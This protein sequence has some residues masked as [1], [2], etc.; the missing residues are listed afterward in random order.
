[1]SLKHSDILPLASG[2]IQ[3]IE[4]RWNNGVISLYR[5]DGVLALARM[6]GREI[7]T[8]HNLLDKSLIDNDPNIRIAALEALPLVAEQ[9]SGALFEVLEVLLEDPDVKVRQAASKCLA[10]TAAT[11]PSATYKMLERELRHEISFRKEHAWRGLKE[12]APIWPEVTAEHLDIIFQ[13]PD[14]DLRRRGAKILR[15]ILDKGGAAVWDLIS[16]TLQ[17]EDVEVRRA[18]ANTLRPLAEKRPKIA[19]IIAENAL[20][21]PDEVVR[22]RVIKC[23]NLLDIS[24]TK[25]RSLVLSG[26]RHRDKDVR[27]ACVKMIPRLFSEKDARDLAQELLRQEIDKKIIGMLDDIIFESELEGDE[28]EK[29]AGLAPAIPVPERD[30]EIM[31]AQGE[32]PFDRPQLGQPG[33]QV[34]PRPQQFPGGV[35]V[36]GPQ[37]LEQRQRDQH[38]GQADDFAEDDFS[39]DE[40]LADAIADDAMVAAEYEAELAETVPAEVA[41]IE[42]GLDDSDRGEDSARDNLGDGD[43]EVVVDEFVITSGLDAGNDFDLSDAEFDEIDSE[44]H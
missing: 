33:V 38:H 6:I 13:E 29:N 26:V 10:S 22:E 17:D 27:I 4:V 34:Q 14:I 9:R 24:S 3:S 2:N 1:M 44:D 37:H 30:R 42:A 41:I 11:F 39:E 32:V 23:L 28:R 8:V 36:E 43:E 20:F 31:A 12:L 35:A 5:E 21:D 15:R 40:F 19:L 7:D 25:F 18:S 16:W